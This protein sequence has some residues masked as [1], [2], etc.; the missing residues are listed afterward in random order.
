MED[1]IAKERDRQK[2]EAYFL[3]SR[4]TAGHRLRALVNVNEEAIN[5]GDS[6]AIVKTIAE[7][8]TGKIPG[9][10]RFGSLRKSISHKKSKRESLCLSRDVPII[11]L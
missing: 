9:R 1:H 3:V 7:A 2:R 6:D 11:I 8:L 5:D 4:R 10:N